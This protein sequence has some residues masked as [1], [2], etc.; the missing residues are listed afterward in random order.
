MQK[1]PV[2]DACVKKK[3][4]SMHKEKGTSWQK[5]EAQSFSAVTGE[6]II[7]LN[8]LTACGSQRGRFKGA[9]LG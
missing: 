3:G 9:T 5:E 8:L 2:G 6:L 7:N 1:L 4:W